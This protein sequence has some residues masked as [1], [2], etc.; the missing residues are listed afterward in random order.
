ME[1]KKKKKKKGHLNRGSH[2][3]RND[4]KNPK[5]PNPL[6]KGS[7]LQTEGMLWNSLG[8]V[9][10]ALSTIKSALNMGWGN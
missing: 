2:R 8:R 10:S 9:Y 4:K 7:V 5:K 1:L 6:L 3:T